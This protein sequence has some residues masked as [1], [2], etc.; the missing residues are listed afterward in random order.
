M[1]FV[2]SL[3]N[4]TAAGALNGQVVAT[5]VARTPAGQ[6]I[7]DTA[8]GRL[9]LAAFA[10]DDAGVGSQIA[11]EIAAP[12]LRPSA[13][14]PSPATFAQAASRNLGTLA[15]QWPALKDA[16]STLA[17]VNPDLARQIMDTALPQL[18]NPRFVAQVLSF[19]ATSATD[20]KTLLGQ[21]AV[22]TLQQAGHGDAAA[23][24]QTDL[25]TM[26][27][28]NAS[29]TDW[30]I[31]Y[32]PLLDSTEIRQLRV[33]TRRRKAG[34]DW[35]RD[36]GRFVVDVEFEHLGSLQL[37]G[38]IQKPRLDLILRSHAELPSTLQTGISGVFAQTCEAAGLSG[39]L[40]FQAVPSFPV[41][42]LD[43]M[44]ASTAH[45]LSI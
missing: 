37:D 5:V 20:V 41:S 39:T 16:L 44:T 15:T 12:A 28:L 19:L 10:P 4:L 3:P 21:T 2:G 32:V 14:A 9:A 33:F 30:R 18:G 1:R 29:A 23:R 43:E 38:L 24:L 11:F 17:A 45:G 8:I 6:M 42:P 34:S 27:R 35:K 22:D 13:A 26:N 36:S 31:F 7:I 40:F 25:N